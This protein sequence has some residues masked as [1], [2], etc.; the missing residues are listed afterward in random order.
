MPDR[1]SLGSTLVVPIGDN[2]EKTRLSFWQKHAEPIPSDLLQITGWLESTPERWVAAVENG[3]A[4]P[5][6]AGDKDR[7]SVV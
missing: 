5:A 6:R 7:K 2:G 4:Q 1:H 3:R